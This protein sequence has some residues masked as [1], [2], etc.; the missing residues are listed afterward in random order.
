MLKEL[1]SRNVCFYTTLPMLPLC[2]YHGTQAKNS[3]RKK[4]KKKVTKAKARQTDKRSQDIRALRKVLNWNFHLFISFL[5]LR[6]TPTTPLELG[7]GQV[8]LQASLNS[9]HVLAGRDPRLAVLAATGEGKILGHDAL[10][11]DDVNAGAL[12]LLSKD[13]DFRRVVELA[14]ADETTGPG[15]DRGNGI[16]GGLTALLVLTVVAGDR[17][18]GSL[19]LEGR[20][21]RGGKSGGH[22]TERAEAL[23]DNVGLN[24]TVV[25]WNWLALA[26]LLQGAVVY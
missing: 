25:V 9:L 2:M 3:K 21:V 18:V 13:N 17:A 16:G 12:E 5:G 24:I 7:V 19:G 1:I 26:Q 6:S 20:T 15:K 4:K 10:L 8:G 22:E 23:G 14:T 11:V